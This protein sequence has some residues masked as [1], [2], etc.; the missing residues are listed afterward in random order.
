MIQ[1]LVENLDFNKVNSMTHEECVSLI[2]SLYNDNLRFKRERD[3]AVANMLEYRKLANADSYI[4][5][6]EQMMLLFPEIETIVRYNKD[7]ITEEQGSNQGAE[8]PKRKERKPRKHALRLPK[9]TPRVVLDYAQFAPETMVKDGIEY[10]RGDNKVIEQISYVPSKKVVEIKIYP[11]WNAACEVEDSEKKTIIG[12]RNETVDKISCAPSMAAHI[13][14]SKYDDH[15]P[16]YRQS[17][18]LVRDGLE[19]QRQTLC[20]W[21]MK[22]YETLIGF[23]KYFGEQVFRMNLINQDE[24]PVE[25]LSVRSPS[26]KISSSSFVIIRV[27]TTFDRKTHSYHR[28]VHMTYSPGRSRKQLFEGFIQND[29]NGPFMTDGLKG[30]LNGPI[31]DD[32]HSV[33]WVHAVRKL[34]KYARSC[35][36]DADAFK[37]LSLHGELYTIESSCRALLD[38]GR[39]TSDEFLERRKKAAEPVI[40]KIIDHAKKIS[41]PGEKTPKQEAISY[42]LEYEKFLYTYLESV[43]CTPDNNECERRAKAFAT[44]RK[45]WL[46][47]NTIDGADTSCFFY[48]L[49]ETAKACGV[50]PERY[51][52]YVLTYGPYAQKEDYGKLLPWNADLDA[53]GKSVEARIN[54]A[55]DPE[56]NEDYILTGFTR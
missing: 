14:V 8:E 49:I 41:N 3:E 1:K 38:S 27:G 5:S 7:E 54:A 40:K 45:N 20:S 34:K 24:T 26:G 11:T 4:P 33:C 30:Y 37:I 10:R 17:E 16:L 50:N 43:E 36:S 9:S 19:I 18:M 13:A 53:I 55:A 46:F 6:T 42:L 15:L 25:V 52:E 22:Y 29:Y 47:S 35:R 51:L 21:L 2:I 28:M 23:E 32:K 48:S 12:F 31:S 56:R 44:G 39:I